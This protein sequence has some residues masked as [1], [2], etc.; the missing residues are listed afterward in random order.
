MSDTPD[1]DWSPPKRQRLAE[2]FSL[3]GKIGFWTQL[4]LLV[5]PLWLTAHV[6]LL[7]RA[8]QGAATGINLGNYVSF[9]S[10]LVMIFTTYWFFRYIR[11]GERMRDPERSPPRSSVVT[12]LWVGLWAGC[13]G[14]AFSMLLLL[15]AAWRMLFVL[16]TNP[17]SGMIL[18]PTHGTDPGYTLSAIDAVSLTSL[19]ISLGAELIVLSLTLWLLFRT[20]WAA[21][22]GIEAE[23]EMPV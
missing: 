21:P 5:V 3:L 7:R 2:Q 23:A 12:T 17:Q 16:L 13:L 15:G 4:A 8:G 1:I 14:I 19:I 22:T 9:G 10:L 20:T 6:F 18:A 11:L